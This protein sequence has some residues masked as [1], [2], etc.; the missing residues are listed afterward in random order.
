[1][2]SGVNDSK[3]TSYYTLQRLLVVVKLAIIT[4]LWPTRLLFIDWTSI[5]SRYAV[6]HPGLRAMTFAGRVFSK[7]PL[8]HRFVLVYIHIN[9]ISGKRENYT[10][11]CKAICGKYELLSLKM[12]MFGVRI[13]RNSQMTHLFSRLMILCT[14]SL[15][16]EWMESLISSSLSS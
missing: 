6:P 12:L 10:I 1:M 9:E 8:N 4:S 2:I 13:T 14:F 11:S 7:H 15:K 5:K 3:H 16:Y